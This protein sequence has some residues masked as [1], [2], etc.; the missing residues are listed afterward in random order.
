MYSF[1]TDKSTESDD[2]IGIRLPN[3]IV[4]D[5]TEHDSEHVAYDLETEMS[6]EDDILAQNDPSRVYI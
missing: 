3:M 4:P 6:I 5:N 1:D 2:D